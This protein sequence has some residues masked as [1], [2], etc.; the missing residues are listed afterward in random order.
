MRHFGKMRM[1]EGV[2]DAVY[3]EQTEDQI[4]RGEMK[5]M[6]TPSFKYQK[7]LLEDGTPWAEVRQ[8]LETGPGIWFIVTD[9]RGWV[10]SVES[11]PE[12]IIGPH[13]YDLWQIEHDTADPW[14]LR[15]HIWTGEEIVKDPDHDLLF[16]VEPRT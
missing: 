6:V 3:L 9:E 7:L 12:Q 14:E 11:D 15:R 10:M 4:A 13:G 1:E 5:Y 16:A 2:K 8:T